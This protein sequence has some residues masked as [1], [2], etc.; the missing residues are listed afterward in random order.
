MT[1]LNVGYRVL[2]DNYKVFYATDT[3]TLDGISARN[4]DLYLVEGNY[5]LLRAV[6]PHTFTFGFRTDLRDV[7]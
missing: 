3:R 1:Y 7:V 5:D 6:E 4:Y 2:F